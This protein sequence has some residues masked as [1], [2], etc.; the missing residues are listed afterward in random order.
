MEP[1]LKFPQ[2]STLH[3]RLPSSFKR[4]S[5]ILA[6]ASGPGKPSKASRNA[7]KAIE[8]H[9]RKWG[10]PPELA[11]DRDGWHYM[12]VGSAKGRVGIVEI[13][14]ES[15]LHAEGVVM[16]RLPSDRDLIVPLMR[17][18]L[19]K[20]MVLPESAKFAIVNDAVMVV[21]TR[22]LQDLSPDQ[23]GRAIMAVMSVA[24]SLDDSFLAKYGGTSKERKSRWKS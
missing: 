7:H 11:T 6:G 15:F 13:D 22:P 9:L 2:H 8:Q 19:E 24:D 5:T 4:L 12:M 3:M 23:I 17:E 14:E 10:L 21:I 1:H 18:L 16:S 20:N